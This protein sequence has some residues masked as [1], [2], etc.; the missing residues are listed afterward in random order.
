MWTETVERFVLEVIAKERQDK[1]AAVIRAVLFLLSK[2]F[3]AAVR[4][5]RWFSLTATV[6]RFRHGP[7]LRDAESHL[8]G[9]LRQRGRI[10]R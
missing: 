8:C 6:E 9:S 4:L 5:R 1:K 2:V 3:H 7:V 10:T